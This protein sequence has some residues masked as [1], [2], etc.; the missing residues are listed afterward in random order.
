MVVAGTR[1]IRLAPQA[2]FDQARN[3]RPVRL[4]DERITQRYHDPVARLALG[5]AIGLQ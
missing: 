3:Q 1:K 5:V 4:G 2:L